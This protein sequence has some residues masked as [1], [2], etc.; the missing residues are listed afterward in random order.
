MTKI[1]QIIKHEYLRHVV[2]KKFL[3]SLL[4]LPFMVVVMFGVAIIIILLSID[5]TPV[6]YIDHP[7]I[8]TQAFQREQDSFLNPKIDFLSYEDKEQAQTDLESEEIQAYYVIPEDYTSTLQVELFF[9][10]EPDSDVQSQFDQFMRQNLDT[11]QG[12]D[13]QVINRLENGIQITISDLD[14]ER[15]MGQDQWYLIFTP[16]VLGLM[17]FFVVMTSGGY[18]SQAVVEEKENRTMEIVITS[19]S[20]NQLMTGKIIGNIALG[21]TQLLAW[22]LFG[23]IGI[24]VAGRIWPVVQEFTLSTDYILIALLVM[25]PAFLMIAAL[26]AAI[27]ATMTETSESQQISGLFSITM[28]IPYY[29]ATPIMMNPN[30]TIATVLTFFPFTAPITILMRMALTVVTQWQLILAFGILLLSAFLAIWFAGK[31]FRMGMLRYGKK[32]SL[33][34]IFK[35]EARA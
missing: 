9:L 26:M 30:G 14:G 7:G 27:G 24:N 20:P 11:L 25:I 29:L 10:D 18:L 16:F 22:L 2:E 13:P 21:L 23:W 12:L 15:E 19:V 3:I 5:D 32:L 31:A 8:L 1:W 33:K 28:M 17:F 6:G 34:E 35:K 4:S